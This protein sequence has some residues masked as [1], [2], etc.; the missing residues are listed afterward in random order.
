M[1]FFGVVSNATPI[2]QTEAKGRRCQCHAWMQKW[3]DFQGDDDSG[4]RL[5]RVG[6][7][8]YCLVH[9]PAAGYLMRAAPPHQQQ[10]QFRRT[11]RDGND[12]FQKT[13]TCQQIKDM[14]L[15]FI[16]RTGVVCFSPVLLLTTPG[17]RAT[18][19]ATTKKK[20]Y[21]TLPIIEL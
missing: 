17:L 19:G 8:L 12:C 3:Q 5:T 7:A 6:S 10:H 4:T 2:T 18:P 1:H 20:V 16:Q 9:T 13:D 21:T 11:N 14:I 15:V